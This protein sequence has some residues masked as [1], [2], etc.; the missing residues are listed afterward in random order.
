[1]QPAKDVSIEELSAKI[2]AAKESPEVATLS[3][4]S[5]MILAS[6]FARIEEYVRSRSFSA[7]YQHYLPLYRA[8]KPLSSYDLALLAYAASRNRDQDNLCHNVAI[9]SIQKNP[10]EHVAYAALAMLSMGR[11]QLHQA[12]RYAQ[13]V[14][15]T[16][17]DLSVAPIHET[18]SFVEFGFRRGT[19]RA[20]KQRHNHSQLKPN[21]SGAQLT[22]SP[23]NILYGILDL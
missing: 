19:F 9:T 20:R 10:L 18:V 14:R 13:L 23:G 8:S 15:L 1:M 22:N 16:G 2:L 6:D 5:S 7:I 12:F 21:F 4:K 11:A 3:R 17:R